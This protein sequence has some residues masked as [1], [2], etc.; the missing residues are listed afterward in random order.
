MSD[1]DPKEQGH[2]RA[3]MRFLRNRVGTW[4]TVAA[5][6][7]SSP[8]TIENVIGG[9]E[10]SASLALRVARLLDASMDDLLAGRFQPGACPKCGHVPSYMPRLESDFAD[11][12]TIVEDALRPAAGLALVK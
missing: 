1:L 3:A 2:V 12:S 11:E 6:L 8:K 10:V 9:R 4:A 7:H 5:A